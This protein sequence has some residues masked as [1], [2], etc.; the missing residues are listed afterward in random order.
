[1]RDK[2]DRQRKYFP[3]LAA[4]AFSVAAVAVGAWAGGLFASSAQ[5][6]AQPSGA[7]IWIAGQ[8]KP[9]AQP[10]KP[11]AKR[12]TRAQR[13]RPQRARAR[14]RAV[15]RRLAAMPT[16][17]LCAKAGT[18][19]MPDGTTVPIWGF[20]LR[21]TGAPCDDPAI[22][23]TLP[24]PAL[25]VDLN[26]D[27]TL[28]VTNA[29]TDRTIS[30]EAAGIDFVPGPQDAAPGDTVSL[31]FTASSQGTYL[32]DSA[33]DGGRQKTMGLYG[34]LVVNAGTANVAYGSSFDLQQVVVLSEVDPAFSAAPDSFDMNNWA[35]KFWLINGQAYPDTPAIDASAGQTLLL[36]Y[37]N[38]GDDHS[39]MTLLGLHQRLIARDAYALANPFSVVAETMP[40]SQT[41]DALVTVP[42]SAAVGTKYPLYNRN[43]H[44]TNGTFG[45]S[46][47]NPGGMMT[48]IRVG[49]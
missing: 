26:D 40:A 42:G 9:G 23:P 12:A 13:A 20:A 21:P 47:Y 15:T 5:K 38:A 49:P 32:Y 48:F 17:N 39:T 22:V 8:A 25:S 43:L 36:R 19:A 16:I 34:S 27:V 7:P 10:A 44:L 28:N 4:S 1:M 31:T 33:G 2:V 30:F 3:F 6:T 35:P 29:L 11:S 37:L 24:G 41:I 45:G 46:N 14:R 18:A